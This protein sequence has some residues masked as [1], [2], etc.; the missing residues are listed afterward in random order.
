MQRHQRD[1]DREA[2]IRTEIVVDSKGTEERAMSW[3]HYLTDTLAFPFITQ[4]RAK[5]AISPLQIGDEV[6][7]IGMA[8]EAECQHEIFV[9]M[10]WERDGLAVPLSQLTVAYADDETRQAVEDWL[11]WVD[12]GYRF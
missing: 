4:C 2:R 9:L 11:Y 5:R 6:D 1:G 12:R 8:P 3:Y 7:V 10:R